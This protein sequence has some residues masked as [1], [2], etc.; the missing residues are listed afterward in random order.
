M[1]GNQLAINVGSV[2][3]LETTGD[4][5][6][7]NFYLVTC[8]QWY[9]ASSIV[10]MSNKV[11]DSSGETF[12]E[13][14]AMTVGTYGQIW[15][16]WAFKKNETGT[17]V[18]AKQ[19][20]DQVIFVGNLKNVGSAVV[21]SL[22]N[23]NDL[24]AS[25]AKDTAYFTTAGVTAGNIATISAPTGGMGQ[26]KGLSTSTPVSKYNEIICKSV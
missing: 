18:I 17:T 5:L 2:V 7:N 19:V 11:A 16:L 14:A 21:F 20:P 26:F 8:N 13:W 22:P 12:S 25:G 24:Y 10:S 15:G 3:A 23:A 9:L 4:G 6:K 1:D